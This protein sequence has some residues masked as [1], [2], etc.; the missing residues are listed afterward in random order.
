MLCSHLCVSLTA[1]LFVF[2][3][4]THICLIALNSRYTV[5]Y[6]HWSITVQ[7]GSSLEEDQLQW[8]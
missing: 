7:Y 6:T 4:V 2:I 3:L 5:L 1:G 8:I